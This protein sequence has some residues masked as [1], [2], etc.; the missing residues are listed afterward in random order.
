MTFWKTFFASLLATIA[1]GLLLMVIFFM[2]L[3][4]MVSGIDG[5][6]EA[7]NKI[8]KSNAVLHMKLNSKVG[9]VSYAYMDPMSFQPIEQMGLVDILSAIKAAKTDNR[10]KGIYLNVTASNVGMAL[11]K[12]IRIA[13]EDFKSSGK[14]L[15]AYQENYDNK[16]YYLSSVAQEIYQYPTGMFGVTGLGAEIPFIKGTLDLL[17]V[18]MQIIRGTNN[19][20]KSAVEPLMYTQMSE[21]NRLQTQKYLN[22]LWNEITQS[23]EMSRNISQVEINRIVDSV[24]TRTPQDAADFK[25]I[26]AVKYYDEVANIMREKLSISTSEDLNLFPFRDYVKKKRAHDAKSNIAVV[27]LEGEIVDGNGVTGQI[28]GNSSAEL[29]RK[30]RQDSTVKAVVLRVN[31]GGGSALASDLIWREVELTKAVKPVVVSMGNVAASGGYYVACGANRIFAQENTITGSIGVFGVIPYTGDVMKEKLGVTFDH[32]QTNAHSVLSLNKRLTAGELKIIQ[33][34]VDDIYLDFITKVGL[35]RNM[36]T[37]Q[38]DS[39]GQGRVWAGTDAINIGLIDEFGG[40]NDAIQY[41][42]SLI[43]VDSTSDIETRIETTNKTDKFMQ[44]IQ[45]MNDGGVQMPTS[46]LQ[47]RLQEIYHFL[48]QLEQAKGVQARMPYLLWID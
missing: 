38:V 12:E 39:I 34:G 1:S 20:F 27:S 19:K 33:H 13:L 7:P 37:A 48:S 28:G 31:S 21:A 8:L 47:T 10:I 18:E 29:I 36:T 22:A 16:S 40:L 14:F 17:G 44:L 43:G 15:I 24:L 30:I 46:T 2:I 32:V 25:F 9:D 5:L 45:N 23:I 35:G 4:A 6:F 41:A 11:L 42:A 3:G 26:D